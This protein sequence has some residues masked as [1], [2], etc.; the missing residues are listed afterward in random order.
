MVLLGRRKPRSGSARG[1]AANLLPHCGPMQV[2]DSAAIT[3]IDVRS[4][5]N[6]LGSQLGLK[7]A[8]AQRRARHGHEG[9]LPARRKRISPSLS[10]EAPT[11]VK[12]DCDNTTDR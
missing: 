3:E 8:G 4:S 12:G 10:F 1:S 5:P 6:P 11:P 9:A 2:S 7:S